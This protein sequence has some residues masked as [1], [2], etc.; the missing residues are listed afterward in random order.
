MDDKN[1]KVLVFFAITVALGIICIILHICDK[2]GQIEALLVTLLGGIISC[3]KDELK[4]I[5]KASGLF[6]ALQATKPTAT[7]QTTEPVVALQATKPTA[8]SQTT[9]PVDKFKFSSDSEEVNWYNI[10]WIKQNFENKLNQEIANKKEHYGRINLYTMKDNQDKLCCGFYWC[11]KFIN[12]GLKGGN[13]L[14]PLCLEIVFSKSINNNKDI[15]FV[16]LR[17]RQRDG[18]LTNSTFLYNHY[19][20]ITNRLNRKE[21][22]PFDLVPVLSKDGNENVVNFEKYFFDPFDEGKEKREMCRQA[23]IDN[24]NGKMYCVWY[25]NILTAKPKTL[26][27][28]ITKEAFE[29]LNLEDTIISCL[30]KAIELFPVYNGK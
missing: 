29:S 16:G 1:N 14:S 2:M 3:V 22:D 19:G 21:H 8:T 6:S 23:K 13:E 26:T 11:T 18:F 5:I 24:Y 4:G 30:N 12:D 27:S 25:Y 20:D 9:E 28:K 15:I 7:S 10:E 17:F